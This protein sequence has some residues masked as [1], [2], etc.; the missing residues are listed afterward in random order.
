MAA[1]RSACRFFSNSSRSPTVCGRNT[2]GTPPRVRYP[3][4]SRG[5]LCHRGPVDGGAALGAKIIHR[6]GSVFTTAQRRMLPGDAGIVQ[7][8]IGGFCPAPEYFPSG[9]GG[10]CRRRAGSA[11][12]R[13]PACGGSAAGTG[14]PAPESAPKAPETAAVQWPYQPVIRGWALSHR[15]SAENSSC[16]PF[17]PFRKNSFRPNRRSLS[18]SAGNQGYYSIIP[19]ACT[20][21]PTEKHSLFILF[22]LFFT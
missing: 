18:P 11:G 20:P 19:I 16:I 12:P 3:P 2:S 7:N 10:Y 21:L 13:P 1:G 22:F 8:R 5:L 14:W 4:A 15:D 9:S 17:P 6:P